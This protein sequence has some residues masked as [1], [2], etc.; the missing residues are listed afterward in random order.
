MR[1]NIKAIC[2]I[3]SAVCPDKHNYQ[4]HRGNQWNL[5]KKTI[6]NKKIVLFYSHIQKVKF[7]PLQA[8][9]ALRVVR[10]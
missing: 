6:K 1:I 5:N 2:N 7:S 10:G 9:E 4:K 3:S 8:L